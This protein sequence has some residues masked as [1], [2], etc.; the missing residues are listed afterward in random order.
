MDSLYTPVNTRSP[1]ASG[2]VRST[3]HLQRLRWSTVRA[4]PVAG[5]SP[6]WH[7]KSGSSSLEREDPDHHWRER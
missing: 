1:S 5:A 7:G 3:A 2:G 6:T 4:S